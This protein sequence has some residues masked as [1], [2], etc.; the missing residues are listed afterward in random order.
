MRE[1]PLSP[2][3]VT[4]EFAGAGQKNGKKATF[5]ICKCVDLRVA[6]AA[7]AANSLLLRPLFHLVRVGRDQG[8]M[9]DVA[10]ALNQTS[11]AANKNECPFRRYRVF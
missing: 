10:K 3:D 5:S 8:T 1:P 2:D 4:A 11:R 6:P 7:R 9:I